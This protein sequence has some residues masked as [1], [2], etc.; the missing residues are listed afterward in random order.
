MNTIYEWIY[1]KI[2]NT[3]LF[4]DGLIEQRVSGPFNWQNINLATISDTF[5]NSSLKFSCFP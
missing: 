5:M 3:E 4:F 1:V 2:K